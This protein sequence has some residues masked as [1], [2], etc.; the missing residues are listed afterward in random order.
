MKMRPF[1]G[2]DDQIS[3]G[4]NSHM[5]H[6]SRHTKTHADGPVG[7]SL[8]GKHPMNASAVVAIDKHAPFDVGEVTVY[9]SGLNTV[10]GK[11]DVPIANEFTVVGNQYSGR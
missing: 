11:I 4:E 6:H 7:V 1:S 8:V 9:Y 10:L 5:A 3:R 2:D